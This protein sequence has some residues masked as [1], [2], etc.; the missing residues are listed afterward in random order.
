MFDPR[1]AVVACN[2]IEN[3]LRDRYLLF[4][5]FQDHDRFKLPVVD[6]RIATASQVVQFQ[7]SLIGNKRSRI[8]L[9]CNQVMDKVLAHPFLGSEHQIFSSQGIENLKTVAFFSDFCIVRGEI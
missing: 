1:H 3:I 2:L 8:I 4:F 9:L 7:G 5:V 6:H